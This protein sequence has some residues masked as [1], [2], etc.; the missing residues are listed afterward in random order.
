[1]ANVTDPV[2]VGLVASLARPGGNVTGLSNM[3]PELSGKRLELLKQIVPQVARV[4][5]LGDPSSPA[6]APGW[7]ETESA[8]R[9]LGVQV[10]SVGV[11]EPNP[12]FAGAFAA[13]T[14]YRADGLLTLSQPLLDVY[15]EQIV[16]FT[17]TRRMP[18]IFHNRGYVETGGLTSYGANVPELY[19]RAASFVDRI[20]KGARPADLPVEQPTTF[21]FVINLKTAQ[22]LG[23]TIPPAVL[24][25][26]TE[27]IQ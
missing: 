3:S 15:R 25:Q 7:R 23:L 5:A 11:S 19:R 8:A 20:L 21:D 26:A 14:G 6:H 1:M 22:V 12:D 18:A 2:G 17:T 4:A 16:D 9:S 10:Q 13:I 24:Q 27:L